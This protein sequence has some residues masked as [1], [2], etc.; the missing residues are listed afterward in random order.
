MC[1]AERSQSAPREKICARGEP[2]ESKFTV[3]GSQPITL[4][5]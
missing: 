5:V 4:T 2:R 3:E 1:F